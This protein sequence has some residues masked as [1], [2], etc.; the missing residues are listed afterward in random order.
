MS[1][2]GAS[3]GH[4]PTFQ[5]F[6]KFIGIKFSGFLQEIQEKLRDGIPKMRLNMIDELEKT[7]M[8]RE[9][10][11]CTEELKGFYNRMIEKYANFV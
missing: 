9:Y 2:E 5:M 6:E 8:I 1:C 11:E 4:D 3:G 10:C 7:S